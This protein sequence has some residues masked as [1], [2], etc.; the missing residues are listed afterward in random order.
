MP[1]AMLTPRLALPLLAAGQA[2][3]EI[4]HN[5]ALTLIDALLCPVIEAVGVNAPPAAPEAG[6]AW[7]VGTAPT[8]EWTGHAHAIAIA[9]AGGWRFAAMPEGATVLVRIDGGIWRRSASGW[10]AP[11][12]I[13][14]PAGGATVDSECRAAVSALISA[15]EARGL[16]SLA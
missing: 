9:T 1:D 2:Q 4:T 8:G 7:I 13:A 14:A 15:L 10:Q 6:Q 5:E 11:L 12:P 3:K 16:V